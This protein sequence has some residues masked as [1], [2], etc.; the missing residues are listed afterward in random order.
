MHSGFMIRVTM[1]V[2]TEVAILYFL[3][4]LLQN[5]QTPPVAKLLC[6]LDED[7]HLEI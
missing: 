1:S 7:L 2:H 5:M 6:C 3:C 4:H